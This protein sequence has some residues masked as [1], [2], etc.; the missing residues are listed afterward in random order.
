M[1]KGHKYSIGVDE[2]GRGPVAGPLC[3]SALCFKK[4]EPKLRKI[5]KEVRDSKKLSEKKRKE[6]H[7]IIKDEEKIGNIKFA[8]FFINPAE[9]DSFGITQALQKATKKVLERLKP[10]PKKALILLD[11]G[12]SAPDKFIN[13]K[14]IIRGDEK[15]QEIACASIVAKISRDRRMRLYDKKFP[16][17]GF[18]NN[19]GY[20][21]KGHLRSIRKFGLSPIHRKSFLSRYQK[22]YIKGVDIL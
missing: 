16:D 7:N 20:G 9:I 8:V 10:E 12:L 4:N 13:Q 3:V 5:F 17:Y 2:V 19:K 15:H 21:T 11:G 14:T 6:W 22:K 18:R 1:K